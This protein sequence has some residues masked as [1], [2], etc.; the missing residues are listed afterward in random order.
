MSGVFLRNSLF[1]LRYRTCNIISMFFCHKQVLL[2]NGFPFVRD[3]RRGSRLVE[4]KHKRKHKHKVCIPRLLRIGIRILELKM[5]SWSRVQHAPAPLGG[6]AGP[7]G[8]L[9][10]PQGRRGRTVVEVG[11]L[12]IS[13][14]ESISIRFVCSSFCALD[15]AFRSSR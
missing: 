15:S 12:N 14:S 11:W 2:S 9:R 4:H 3:N 6:L 1:F 10:M 7:L 5:G 8:S 13:I